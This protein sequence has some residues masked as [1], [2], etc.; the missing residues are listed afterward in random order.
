[1]K[2]RRTQI[3][4]SLATI[5]LVAGFVLVPGKV[6]GQYINTGASNIVTNTYLNAIA[7]TGHDIVMGLTTPGIIYNWLMGKSNPVAGDLGWDAKAL[8][9]CTS[10]S[11]CVKGVLIVLSNISLSVSNLILSL[12]GTILNGVMILTINM[13]TLLGGSNNI[14]DASWSVIRD[15]ASI[16][17][18][19][20]LLYTSIEIIIGVSDSKVKHIIIMV[21]IAGI[22]I[23][24]SLFFT[25]AAIDASNLV[26]LAFYRAI[27]PSGANF[28]LS[29][30]TGSIY[31]SGG[32]AN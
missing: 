8:G 19:F 23:N 25:K 5:I 24:F 1:M 10:V 2:S 29:N 6:R 31:T 22:L 17:I 12:A 13:A 16:I 32:I 11:D 18:I 20:F 28:S 9:L 4:V 14:I 3:I 27:A 15:M 7:G 26:G 30:N 21:A